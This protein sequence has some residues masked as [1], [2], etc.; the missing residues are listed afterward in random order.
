MGKVLSEA[1]K[2]KYDLFVS[3]YI[4]CFNATKAAIEAGYKVSNAKN[5][6]SNM[7]TY[8]YIKEKIDVELGR[9]RQRFADEGNRA[10]A[11]LLNI[12]SD[13]DL[14]LRRHDEAELEITRLETELIK[15]REEYNIM[16][17]YVLKLE[18][19]AK[20]LDGRKK[21][22]RTE[23]SNLLSLIDEQLDE[24]FEL[25]IKMSKKRNEISIHDKHILRPA[26]WEKMLSLKAD[27]LQDILDRGGFKPPDK[28]EHSGHLGIPVNPELTKLTKEELEVIAKQFRDGNTS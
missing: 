25:E 9:L 15:D 13:L 3:A 17:R 11:D 10:F 4:R 19:K 5:Q 27:V 21:D 26:Q 6:G 24:L 14:K 18:S 12:L 20:S 22:S 1:T 16:D 2:Q 8:P 23:K 7:L 28:V